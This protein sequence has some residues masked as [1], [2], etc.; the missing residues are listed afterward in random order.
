MSGQNNVSLRAI[1][2]PGKDPPGISDHQFHLYN[3][4]E[5]L[6]RKACA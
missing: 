1:A 3:N 2:N 6:E 5:E 4:T